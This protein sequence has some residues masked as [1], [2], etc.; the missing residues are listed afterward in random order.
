MEPEG[1]VM[2]EEESTMEPK[3]IATTLEEKQQ[4]ILDGF[5]AVLKDAGL[6]GID[7][8]TVGLFIKKGGKRCPAGQKPV[9]RQ[10]VKPNGEIQ[11][12]WVCE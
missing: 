8:S 1:T 4:E 12:M 11:G 2:D 10:V 7:I 6:Q 3:T 9:W 5:R